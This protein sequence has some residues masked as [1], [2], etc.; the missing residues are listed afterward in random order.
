MDIQLAFKAYDQHHQIGLNNFTAETLKKSFELD[1]KY[2][3]SD[4][5]VDAVS[6][7]MDPMQTG[8]ISVKYFID[9]LNKEELQGFVQQ[10]NIANSVFYPALFEGL[11]F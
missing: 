2:W 4:S 8:K 3:M 10:F 9:L 7:F 5:D 6:A 11:E 1:G